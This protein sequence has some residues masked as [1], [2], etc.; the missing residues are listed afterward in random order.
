[1]KSFVDLTGKEK[2]RLFQEAV[3]EEIAEH[4]AAGRPTTHGDGKGVYRLY[5]DGRKEYIKLYDK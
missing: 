2:E 1:M 3:R 4:H 5:P